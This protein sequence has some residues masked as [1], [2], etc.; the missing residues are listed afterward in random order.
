MRQEPQLP[1]L[2]E[3]GILRPFRSRPSRTLS[4][5]TRPNERPSN[6]IEGIIL[7]VQNVGASRFGNTCDFRNQMLGSA[8]FAQ[9]L[10]KQFDDCINVRVIQSFCDQARMP[11]AHVFA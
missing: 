10:T 1:A 4:S 6:S 3:C 7:S 9:A 11:V 2:Q 5:S 8:N